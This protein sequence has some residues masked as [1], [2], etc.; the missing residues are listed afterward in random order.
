V[1]PDV[2]TRILAQKR[3]EVSLL[4]QRTSLA[5]LRGQVAAAPPVRGFLAALRMRPGRALIAEIKRSSPSAG[6][7]AKEVDPAQRAQAYEAGGAAALSVL[8][9]ATFFGGSLKDLQKAREACSLPV[10][11]KDFII[12]LAQV[13]E[14][15]VAGADA[16]LLI[17][18]ALEPVLMTELYACARE[19]GMTSLIEV[20]NRPELERVLGIQPQLV[21]INNRNLKDLK[22][23]LATSLE[24]R[25]LIPRQVTVVAESGVSTPDDVSRLREGGLNAFL[26]GTSLMKAEDPA[27]LIRAMV[28]GN[29][30]AP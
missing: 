17:A 12:S 15:R 9:D 25:P 18:A 30:G 27:S 19:L 4:C 13:Y 23:D 5:E 6:S 3:E 10:L 8:T 1:S 28:N 26:V 16:I 2:L 14:A 20:H 21:G 29:G 7:L 11:R 22:V 24:L